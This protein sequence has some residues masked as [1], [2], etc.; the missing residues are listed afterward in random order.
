MIE[1]GFPIEYAGTAGTHLDA[2]LTVL[3]PPD[4]D[5]LHWY[6]ERYAAKIRQLLV[7]GGRA[8]LYLPTG[9]GK[10]RVTVEAIVRA[11]TED[12]FRG[13][14]LWI[15]QSEE[16]CEQAVQTWSTVWRQFGDRRPLRIGRL[17][18]RNDVAETENEV[19]VIVATDAKL[20]ICREKD[21][22]DWLRRPS[23]VVIDEAHSAIGTDITATLRWL[24]IAGQRTGRPLLGLTATPFKGQSEIATER[25]AA[26][27]DHVKWD[28]F[29]EEDRDAY[30][31]LQEMDVL[32]RIEH[33][34]LPGS[35]F[36]LN[37]DEQRQTKKLRLL[38]NQVLERIGRDEARM[39]RLLEDICALPEDWPVLVFTASVQSAQVLAALLKY[40]GIT[41]AAISGKTRVHERRRAIAEFK[42]DNIRVLTNCSVLTEGF[43]APKVRALYVA[44][45][46]FSPNA[47]I[48]MVGRGLRGEKNGGNRDC[49]V[50]NVEDTFGQFGESL[51]YEEFNHLWK[52]GGSRSA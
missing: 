21:D 28:A 2:D 37:A 52:Q 7:D 42:S 33:R 4:L 50:V 15:A 43:D 29:E 31:V 35:D 9:A 30:E 39:Q 20:A 19:S 18:R 17:W 48:Q 12:D 8:M 32:S 44:R 45:P 10:T 22:Y 6:Q 14:L 11:F 16:L 13:P 40:R 46:T 25:L 26:R 51:A 24:G 41:A 3:G 34:I 49:L 36:V 38:P 47:Y 27:F 23:A 5:P 1:L